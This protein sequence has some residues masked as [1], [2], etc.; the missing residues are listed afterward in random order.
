MLTLAIIFIM[1]IMHAPKAEANV[2][3]EADEIDS[4]KLLDDIKHYHFI[5]KVYSMAGFFF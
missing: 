5:V 4:S 1:T 3:S 2:F